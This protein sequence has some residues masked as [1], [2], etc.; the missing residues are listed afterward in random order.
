[1]KRFIIDHLKNVLGWRTKRRLLVFSVD[2]Y[3]SVRLSSS[4]ARER[5]VGQGLSLTSRFDQLDTLETRDDLLALFDV[6]TNVKDSRGC[7]PIF[8][9]YALSAN[10]DFSRVLGDLQGYAYEP[11]PE[12][13]ERLESSQPQ[14]YQG[15]WQLWQEGVKHRFLYPQFHG[16]EHLNVEMFER[17]L[18]SKSKD[19]VVN[20]ENDSLVAL[21]RD[22]SL[23]GVEFTQAFSWSSNAELASQKEI[24]IDGLKLFHTVFGFASRTFTP[25]AQILHPDLY[26]VACESGVQAIDRPLRD[27]LPSGAQGLKPEVNFLGRKRGQSHLK[28][29]R[30]IV[31]EPCAAKGLKSVPRA[32]EMIAAAF[33]WNKPAIVSSHRVNF[34]GHIDPGNRQRG[35]EALNILLVEIVKKWPDVEFISIDELCSLMLESEAQGFVDAC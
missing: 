25:P 14:A 7:C 13:F 24:L 12:T 11:L 21:T 10:P 17:K 2:D 16:R 8:T 34:A 27:R 4:A 22:A 33:Y 1:M 6:L 20:L 31:F 35:L 9:A 5:I 3:G 30:N 23:P 19:L 29:V 15:T 32:L 26:P 28:L 18:K